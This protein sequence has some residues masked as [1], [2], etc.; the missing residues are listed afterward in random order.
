VAVGHGYSLLDLRVDDPKQS[1]KRL[2]V[3]EKWHEHV[4]ASDLGAE[5]VARRSMLSLQITG[6]G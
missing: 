2:D 6:G 1:R 5:G 3:V 4:D